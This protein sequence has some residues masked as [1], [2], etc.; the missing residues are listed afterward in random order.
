MSEV[1]KQVPVG[2][3]TTW[4]TEEWNNFEMWIERVLY[5]HN[6]EVI[7]TKID[8]TERVMN[9]TKDTKYILENT[10]ESKSTD[11]PKPRKKKLTESSQESGVVTAFDTDLNQWRSFKLRNITNIHALILKYGTQ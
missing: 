6:V 9:C 3:V 2:A 4:S 5:Q 10:P 8:G 11:S 1:T 7:F